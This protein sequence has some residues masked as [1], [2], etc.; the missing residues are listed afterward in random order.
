LHWLPVEHGITFKLLLIIYKIVSGNAPSYL[1]S[2]VDLY[3]PKRTLRSG[4]KRLLNVPRALTATYED[5]AFSIAGPKLWN[6]LPLIIKSADTIDKFKTL[7]KTHL[8][9]GLA[10]GGARL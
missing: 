1:T 3:I 6:Q 9:V 5:R 8:L 2:L 4:N 7:L 10:V